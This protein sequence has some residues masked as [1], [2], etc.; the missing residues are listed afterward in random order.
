MPKTNASIAD[1][2]VADPR[3]AS[4]R[5]PRHWA[6]AHWV[7]YLLILPALLAELL[8]HVVPMLVGLWVSFREL[9]RS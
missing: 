2:G 5:R 9:T 1:G 8:V 7:A 6:R 4:R 3:E